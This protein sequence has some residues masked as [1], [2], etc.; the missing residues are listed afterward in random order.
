[1]SKSKQEIEF[2]EG[3]SFELH[4]ENKEIYFTTLKKVGNEFLIEWPVNHKR[5]PLSI[6]GQMVVNVYY[7]DQVRKELYHF[8]SNIY[9]NEQRQV[10]LH[11]PKPHEIKKAQRRRFFRVQTGVELHLNLPTKENDPPVIK[12]VYTQDI[13]GGGLAFL[14]TVQS[15]KV[16]DQ[17]SGILILRCKAEERS[18]AFQGRVVS[19]SLTPKGIYK[20]AIEYQDLDETIR[21]EIIRFCMYKQIEINKLINEY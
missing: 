1:M 8:S 21:S 13:S 10:V 2:W 15:V 18:V 12:K 11:Y 19:S 20:I 7:Y 14:D 16:N 9:I 3:Q 5:L 4:T 6:V 17:V